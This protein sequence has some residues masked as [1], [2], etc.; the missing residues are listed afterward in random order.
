MI[1]NISKSIEKNINNI[2]NQNKSEINYT[3][4]NMILMLLSSTLIKY[5]VQ[6][7]ISQIKDGDSNG[8]KS[9]ISKSP[10]NVSNLI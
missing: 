7:K 1:A 8:K 6:V 4:L 5:D 2:L 10:I 3:N 9:V